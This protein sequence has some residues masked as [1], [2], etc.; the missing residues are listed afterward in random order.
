VGCYWGNEAW[1]WLCLIPFLVLLGFL[2]MMVVMA[3]RCM[4]AAGAWG[5]GRNIWG[6]VNM[7][8][9]SSGTWKGMRG[10][11]MQSCMEMMSRRMPAA[12]DDKG[13]QGV[14]DRWSTDLEQRI[15]DLLDKRERVEPA[16]LAAALGIPEEVTLSLIHRLVLEGKVRIVS[17]EKTK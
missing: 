6:G 7:K 11:M 2:V 16:E 5:P 3:R 12:A 9:Q 13:M 8:N 17:V 4:S 1:G 10:A 15:L 14:F